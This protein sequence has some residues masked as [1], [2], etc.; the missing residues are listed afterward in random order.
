MVVSFENYESIIWLYIIVPLD[1][2][3][4]YSGLPFPKNGGC[5]IPAGKTET[6]ESL[7]KK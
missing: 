4:T 5:K 1:K 6:R 7:V 2:S 3:L